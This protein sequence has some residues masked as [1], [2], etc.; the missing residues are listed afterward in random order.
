MKNRLVI[1]SP[2]VTAKVLTRDVLRRLQ[3]LLASGVMIY[4]IIGSDSQ[5]RAIKDQAAIQNLMDI[6][7]TETRLFVR[8]DSGIRHSM[9]GADN[10]F[11]AMAF[12]EW[13]GH[14]GDYHRAFSRRKGIIVRDPEGVRRILDRY[15]LSEHT[16]YE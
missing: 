14:T 13:L 4:I 6:A 15:D 8:R 1:V 3:E 11:V 10:L 5:Q 9:L 2:K 12:F 16:G 7:R